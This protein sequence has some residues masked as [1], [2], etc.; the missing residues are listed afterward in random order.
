MS[1]H[2]LPRKGIVTIVFYGLPEGRHG[3][4]GYAGR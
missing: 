2:E 4:T 3:M 1:L